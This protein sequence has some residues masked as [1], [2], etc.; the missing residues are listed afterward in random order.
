[1]IGER[2]RLNRPVVALDVVEPGEVPDYCVH[3]KAV[4]IACGEWVWLGDRTL[5]LVASGQ[6]L[7]LCVPCAAKNIPYGG[8]RVGHVEDHRRADGP[9]E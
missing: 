4:C 5:D 7:P 3:G 8:E 1:M 2:R 6:A 9:H